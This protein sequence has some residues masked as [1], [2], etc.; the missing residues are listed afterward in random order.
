VGKQVARVLNRSPHLKVMVEGHTCTA[1]SWGVT[2]QELAQQRAASVVAYLVKAG[3][4]QERLNS[5]GWGEVLPL[6]PQSQK[7]RNRRVEFHIQARASAQGLRALVSSAA[8]RERLAKD[9]LA[10]EG[11]RALASGN[12][13]GGCDAIVRRA[14]ADVLLACGAEWKVLRLLLLGCLKGEKG[15]RSGSWRCWMPT[16]AA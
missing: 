5:R 3:V 7:A 2:N 4:A 13:G 6:Y 1:P 8:K 16:A 14:A 12:G 11:L 15:R 9:P 10:Q